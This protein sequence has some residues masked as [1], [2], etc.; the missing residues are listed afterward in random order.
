MDCQKG[1]MHLIMRMVEHVVMWV[2]LSAKCHPSPRTT[3]RETIQESVF[4]MK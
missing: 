3:A 4:F 2:S 1:S